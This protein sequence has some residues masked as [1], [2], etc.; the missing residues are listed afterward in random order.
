ML[1]AM[2]T[3]GALVLSVLTFFSIWVVKNSNNFFSWSPD[4]WEHDNDPPRDTKG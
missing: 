3:A 2:V 4:K 1:K